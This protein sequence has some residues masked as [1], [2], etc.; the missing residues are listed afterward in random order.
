VWRAPSPAVKRKALQPRGDFV[1]TADAPWAPNGGMVDPRQNGSAPGLVL[2]IL[3]LVAASVATAAFSSASSAQRER[4]TERA[5]AQAREALLAFAADRPIDADVGPGYLPCPDLDDDGWAESTCGSLAGNVGQEDRLGRLP[6]KT[7]GL[8]D[9]RDGHGERLWYAVST[10]FKGLLNCAA[11]AA[12][13]DM[14]PASAIG[15]IT[16][17]S[18]GGLLLH[19]GTQ[20]LAAAAGG[21]AAVVIA[22]G[23][24]LT[25]IDGHPQRRECAAGDCDARGRCL[26]QP[27]RRAARC[28]PRNYLDRDEKEDNAAFHDRSDAAGRAANGD[29]FVAGPVA[30]GGRIVSN[31][32]IVALSHPDVMARVMARVA[33]E[34]AYCLRLD[35]A[36]RGG[37]AAPA[38]RCP[39]AQHPG[40]IPDEALSAPACNARAGSGWW[41][42]WKPFVVYARAVP[43]GLAVTNPNGGVIAASRRF[44]VLVSHRA[45][46]CGEGRLECNQ[47]G[48]TSA[49]RAAAS[50]ER[51]DA[52]ASSQ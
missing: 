11:S 12:C 10:R 47:A 41:E 42:A 35:A 2:L 25:R 6:W 46:D 28:D 37:F 14:S 22:P 45:G 33:V 19:D 13:V 26:P 3:V 40:A 50:P 30:S 31:D 48:C 38:A 29:G 49:V 21:A 32:R 34:A 18:A 39:G 23:P 4:A 43:E 51:F 20:A 7:L 9:L 1:A 8:P 27:P 5:L 52:I 44:A 15:T 24:P 36:A 16:V 17:R